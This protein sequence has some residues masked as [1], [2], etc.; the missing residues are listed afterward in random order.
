MTV[1]EKGKE[2]E[3]F[4][5]YKALRNAALEKERRGESNSRIVLPSAR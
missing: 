1:A 4:A 2:K 3:I 5:I